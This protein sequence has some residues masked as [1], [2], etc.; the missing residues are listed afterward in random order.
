MW[1]NSLNAAAAVPGQEDISHECF[2][3]NCGSNP[4]AGLNHLKAFAPLLS[5]H[6]AFSCSLYRAR[7]FLRFR[8][9][10][11]PLPSPLLLLPIYPRV[12]SCSVFLTCSGLPYRSSFFRLARLHSSPISFSSVRGPSCFSLFRDTS[13]SRFSF[14][15]EDRVITEQRS[16]L[17]AG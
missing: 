3:R 16:C 12:R 10:P 11:L 9:T 8:L 14:A 2:K 13:E 4:T 17:R 7:G 15:G 5:D 6:P 1:C